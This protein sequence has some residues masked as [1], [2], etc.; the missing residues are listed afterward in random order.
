MNGEALALERNGPAGGLYGENHMTKHDV[1][2]EGEPA[3]FFGCK[4]QRH[5]RRNIFSPIGSEKRCFPFMR[6]VPPAEHRGC[7]NDKENDKWRVEKQ[8]VRIAHAGTLPDSI[9]P[10]VSFAPLPSPR[11]EV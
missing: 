4:V 5:T 6:N 11:G 10:H 1:Q 8:P 3:D 9:Y 2:V 7:G